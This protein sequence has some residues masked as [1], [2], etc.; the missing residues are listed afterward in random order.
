MHRLHLSSLFILAACG[1]DYDL[2]LEKDDELGADDTA[3]TE[4]PDTAEEEDSAAPD[5]DDDA[6]ILQKTA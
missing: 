1:S 4:E 5:E 3:L 2:N 6:V